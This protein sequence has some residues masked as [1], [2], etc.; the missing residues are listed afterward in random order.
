MAYSAEIESFSIISN[1]S[2]NNPL[3]VATHFGYCGH[4]TIIII[5]KTKG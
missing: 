5:Q 2:L 1:S 3:I 4:M